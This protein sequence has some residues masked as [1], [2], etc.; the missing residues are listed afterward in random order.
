MSNNQDTKKNN[1]IIHQSW[2]FASERPPSFSR[3]AKE[4]V[5]Q[6]NFDLDS[7]SKESLF[8]DI[9][10]GTGTTTNNS[11]NPFDSCQQQHQHDSIQSAGYKFNREYFKRSQK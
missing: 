11:D 8:T 3:I 4:S 6:G 9:V 5:C 2:T 7:T 10:G 1:L